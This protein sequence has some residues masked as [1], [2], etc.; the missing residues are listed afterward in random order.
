MS[1]F[2]RHHSGGVIIQGITGREG[3]FHSRQMLAY[4]TNIVAGVTP[5]KGGEWAEGKPIFDTVKA[6]INATGATVSIIFVPAANAA[7]AIIE[8]LDSNIELIICITEGIP[9]SDMMRVKAYIGHDEN[10]LIGPNCPGI[11]VPEQVK[12]GTIPGYVARGGHVGVLTSTG[13]LTYE[14]IQTLS[15]GGIGQ[16]T[17]VGIG[18]DAIIG[19][20]LV[21]ALALFEH[22]P[23][24]EKVVL[25]SENT[26][27][28]EMEA[29]SFIGSTMTK[30]VV[31]YIVGRQN[32]ELPGTV[33]LYESEHPSKDAVIESL[34]VAGVRVAWSPDHIPELLA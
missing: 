21:E 14:I 25:V 11:L 1:V 4:G 31:A 24:T 20:S 7:D 26:G 29:A 18:S 10:R 28:A 13:T 9:V 16:S 32:L 30:P 23:D 8:A 3:S 5:G 17:C 22:D 6:A 27:H 34:K 33:P 19:M 2:V 15:K 12:L